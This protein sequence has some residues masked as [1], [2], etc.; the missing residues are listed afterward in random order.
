MNHQFIIDQLEENSSV[1]ERLLRISLEQ[2]HWKPA[3]EKWS[4]L[5]VV[6]HLY[7]EEREDFRYRLRSVL[8]DPTEPWPPIAPGEWVLQR[9]YSKRAYTP[10]VSSFLHERKKSIEWLRGLTAPDWRSTYQH[11]QIGPMSAEKILS[12]WLAHDYL[13]FRQIVALKFGFLSNMAAPLSLEYAGN[14]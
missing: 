4:L 1:F 11:R 8:D 9:G 13:H 7:D 14:W 6:N 2:V 5:E 3:P 12:N 10:S